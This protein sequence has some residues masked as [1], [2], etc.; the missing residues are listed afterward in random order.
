MMILSKSLSIIFIYFFFLAP[1]HFGSPCLNESVHRIPS[2]GYRARASILVSSD[3]ISNVSGSEASL[4]QSGRRQ[5]NDGYNTSIR[6]VSDCKTF[7]VENCKAS[8]FRFPKAKFCLGQ[9]SS[10]PYVS[11]KDRTVSY[12]VWCLNC[13]LGFL[14][15]FCVV[16]RDAYAW[17]FELY[18]MMDS[19]QLMHI[20]RDTLQKAV[21]GDLIECGVLFCGWLWVS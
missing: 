17:D 1:P 19:M 12:M 9:D 16:T 14:P 18:L 3:A 21:V 15:Y 7:F 5:M 13:A 20:H 8:F 6:N 2:S 11:K 4:Y 10:V